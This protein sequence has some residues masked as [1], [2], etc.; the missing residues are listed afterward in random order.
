MHAWLPGVLSVSFCFWSCVSGEGWS[1]TA[2]LTYST[3]E[4]Y[5]VAQVVTVPVTRCRL[6]WNAIQ[7]SLDK[8]PQE[9]PSACVISIHAA[10]II[11]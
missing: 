9:G 7:H 6:K 10:E 2:E 4:T 8:V 3:W 11:S 5:G 1:L